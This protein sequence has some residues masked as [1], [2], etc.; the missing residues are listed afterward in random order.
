MFDITSVQVIS[1]ACVLMQISSLRNINIRPGSVPALKDL[2]Y[3]IREINMF[4]EVCKLFTFPSDPCL[5]GCFVAI[6]FFFLLLSVH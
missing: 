6:H 3:I 5:S 1:K 4:I 2:Q